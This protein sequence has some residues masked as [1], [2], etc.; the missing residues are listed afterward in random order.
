MN[1]SPAIESSWQAYLASQPETPPQA[2]DLAIVADGEG[3][4]LC[5][6]EITEVEIKPFSEVDEEFAFDYGENDRTLQQWRAASWDYFA[7]CC[8]AIGREPSGAM[9]LVCQRFRVLYPS[10]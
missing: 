9:P 4:S 6:I 2:G 10:V 1:F 5:I 3:E 8:V 7:Q